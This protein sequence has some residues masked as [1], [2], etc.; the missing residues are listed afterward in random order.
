MRW[1]IYWDNYAFSV[2]PAVE[3][4]E[5]NPHSTERLNGTYATELEAYEGAIGTLESV[6]Q[7]IAIQMRFAKRQRRRL[8]A[9]SRAD[10]ESQNDRSG[11]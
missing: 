11:Q 6:R 10:A 8:K 5:R 1:T 7:D 9:K 4:A 3:G 2:D